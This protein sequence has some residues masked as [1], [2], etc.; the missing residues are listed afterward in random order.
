MQNIDD[1]YHRQR[2]KIR[3]IWCQDIPVIKLKHLSNLDKYHLGV[4]L[5][6]Y[7]DLSYMKFDESNNIF[8]FKKKLSTTII[9]FLRNGLFIVN[10]K[11]HVTA[12]TDDG[13]K[14]TDLSLCR[15]D[16]NVD[17]IED[18]EAIDA[19]R[20]GT[21]TL[22]DEEFTRIYE[23]AAVDIMYNYY[24]E[25][26]AMHYGSPEEVHILT[27]VFIK[28]IRNL[29]IFDALD[30]ILKAYHN[31]LRTKNSSFVQL[32]EKSKNSHNKD[33]QIVIVSLKIPESVEI[34]YLY[35]LLGFDQTAFNKSEKELL[36][37]YR[38]A[39]NE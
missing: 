22:S 36:R 1:Y 23:E 39:H 17:E 4:L 5:N 6:C 16:L 9:S 38:E 27:P 28:L 10:R 3:Q 37:I 24:C 15:F 2:S 31:Y 20:N 30:F 35:K 13:L 33:S 8:I 14:F 7:V 32:L 11:I 26:C 19:C 29:S 25:L 18:K 12:F 34:N 21:Y